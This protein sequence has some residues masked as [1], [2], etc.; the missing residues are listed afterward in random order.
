MTTLDTL[1]FVDRPPTAEEVSRVGDNVVSLGG[2]GMVTALSLFYLGCTPRLLS[3]IGERSELESYLPAGF[4]G[5]FLQECLAQMQRTWI[6]ITEDQQ[7]YTFVRPSQP[8]LSA[9]VVPDNVVSNFLLGL[10]VLYVSAEYLPLVQTVVT[11]AAK[12]Q[13]PIVT[14]LSWA[15][16]ADPDP[17]SVVLLDLLLNASHTLLV[18]ETEALE[19]MKRS[20][21]KDWSEMEH[22]SLQQ[23][24]ITSGAEGGRYSSRPFDRWE[25]YSAGN[26]EHTR[27]V[28]GA[29]DTFNG[30]YLKARFVDRRGIADAC[31]VAADVAALKV[32]R[33]GS[34]LSASEVLPLT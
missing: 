8:S 6:A 34:A 14:N 29:G 11:T 7:V 20:G 4:D 2:K 22:S 23:I 15:F 17:G 33:R 18:N 25:R 3:L 27:C 5:S 30:A 9:A 21:F 32:G 31:R 24:V 19:L 1:L 12:R 28:V 16:L 26:P 13:I 10:D